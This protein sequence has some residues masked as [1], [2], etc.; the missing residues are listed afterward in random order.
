MHLRPTSSAV[1]PMILAKTVAFVRASVAGPVFEDFSIVALFSSLE[2]MPS[3]DSYRP[4]TRLATVR[5]APLPVA[6]CGT[7]QQ[8]QLPLE[9]ALQFPAPSHVRAAEAE[10]AMQASAE[11]PVPISQRRHRVTQGQEHAYPSEEIQL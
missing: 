10:P 4:A 1:P 7:H 3:I 11:H 8:V 6:I 5:Q 9:A 2:E